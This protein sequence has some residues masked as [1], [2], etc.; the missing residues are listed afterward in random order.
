[1]AGEPRLV[2]RRCAGIALAACVALSIACG[3]G[4]KYRKPSTPVPPAYKE[5][6]APN[7]QESW[8]LAQ[9]RDDLSRG[10]WWERFND[11]RLN[12][13]QARLNISNQNIA[14]AAADLLVAR[15]LI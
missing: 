5:V 11:P 15:T 3:I 7:V 8:K 1:M 6:G 14:A 4:P 13:L 2:A 12:D 9:P 10:S